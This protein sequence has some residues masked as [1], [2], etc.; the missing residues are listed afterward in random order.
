M[1]LLLLLLLL[2]HAPAVCLWSVHH[3]HNLTAC[4]PSHCCLP[5]LCMAVPHPPSPPSLPPS[6]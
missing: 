3:T 1:L 4:M 6:Q 2:L 5:T